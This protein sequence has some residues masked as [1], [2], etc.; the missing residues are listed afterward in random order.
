LPAMAT[1]WEAFV[2]ACWAGF[3]KNR[4]NYARQSI[5]TRR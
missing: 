5:L 3:C 4:L 1:Q 2:L